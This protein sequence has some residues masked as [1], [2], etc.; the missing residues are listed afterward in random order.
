[1]AMSAVC[2]LN[3]YYN[4]NNN[5]Y[6]GPKFLGWAQIFKQKRDNIDVSS[7]LMRHNSSSLPLVFVH[8]ISY[9]TII[10]YIYKDK[11]C[12]SFRK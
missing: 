2:G 10:S 9:K 8:I 11:F 3:D 4:N 1:M 7:L 12:T 5:L 6:L